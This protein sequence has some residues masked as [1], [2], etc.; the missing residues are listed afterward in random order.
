[1]YSIVVGEWW[2]R[3]RTTGKTILPA[4]SHCLKVS[5]ISEM[6]AFLIRRILIRCAMPS[7]F[8]TGELYGFDFSGLP[9]ERVREL[10]SAPYKSLVCPFKPAHQGK[11][12]AKCNKKGGV[13]SLRQYVQDKRGTV[14][15]K[16]EPVTTWLMPRAALRRLCRL[17]YYAARPSA[18]DAPQGGVW[19]L[20][21]SVFGIITG[22]PRRRAADQVGDNASES[23]W[24]W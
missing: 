21:T 15:G 8:G 9:P 17:L 7:R 3:Q 24:F 18:G 16:G 19:C 23:C 1:V 14:E 12:I 11:P 20:G 22:L 6:R 5:V 4:A 13:C 2:S 10:S